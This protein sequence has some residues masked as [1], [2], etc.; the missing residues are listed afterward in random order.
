MEYWNDGIMVIRD[1]KYV[2]PFKPSIPLFQLE[3]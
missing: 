2:H 1:E 3:E